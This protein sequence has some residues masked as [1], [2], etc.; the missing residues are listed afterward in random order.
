MAAE[1]TTF[2]LYIT[3]ENVDVLFKCRLYFRTP[4]DLTIWCSFMSELGL[5]VT[6][7][8]FIALKAVF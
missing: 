3:A 6:F 2:L 4:S 7:F 5:L 8:F 1:G